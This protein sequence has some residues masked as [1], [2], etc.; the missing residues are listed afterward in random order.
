LVL[1]LTVFRDGCCGGFSSLLPDAAGGA[2]MRGDPGGDAAFCGD[3]TESMAAMYARRESWCK[4]RSGDRRTVSLGDQAIK[5][6]SEKT[7]PA[8]HDRVR[9]SI[10]KTEPG[11][12]RQEDPQERTV[13]DLV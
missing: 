7:T 2:E 12:V 5:W 3:S 1:F 6:Q 8:L 11:K 9:S 13:D 10:P 4:G